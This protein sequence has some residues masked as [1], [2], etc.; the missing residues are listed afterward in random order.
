M[1]ERRGKFNSTALAIPPQWP[2]SS[3]V[4]SAEDP[5]SIAFPTIF[6]KAAKGLNAGA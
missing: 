1:H 6:S 4:G 3:L 5:A 2:A